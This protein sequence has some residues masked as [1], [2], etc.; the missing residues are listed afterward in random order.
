MK[1]TYLIIFLFLTGLCI[2]SEE[3][4]DVALITINEN[5]LNYDQKRIWDHLKPDIIKELKKSFNLSLISKKSE[6]SLFEKGLNSIKTK[7]TNIFKVNPYPMDYRAKDLA[8]IL[9]FYKYTKYEWIIVLEFNPTELDDNPFLISK[10]ASSDLS[11]EAEESFR[12][13]LKEKNLSDEEIAH[14]I[15]SMKGNIKKEKV[16]LKTQEKATIGG[17]FGVKVNCIDTFLEYTLCKDYIFK[18]FNASSIEYARLLHADIV[19]EIQKIDDTFIKKFFRNVNKSKIYKKD[20]NGK[21][22]FLK[23]AEHGKTEWI[24]TLLE[25]GVYPDQIA[26]N[27]MSALMLASQ[28]GHTEI[29]KLLLGKGAD[30]GLESAE[31]KTALDYARDKGKTQIV[32]VLK[33]VKIAQPKVAHEKITGNWQGAY[34]IDNDVYFMELEIFEESS[35]VKGKGIIWTG[36]NNSEKNKALKAKLTQAKIDSGYRFLAQCDFDV[37]I[38]DHEI[39]IKNR[40]FKVLG[41]KNK[42]LWY[43][44]STHFGSGVVYED[45]TVTSLQGQINSNNRITGSVNNY[46]EHSLFCLENKDEPDKTVYTKIG[47][48][49]TVKITCADFPQFHY[50]IYIPTKFDPSKIPLII[51]FDSPNGNANPLQIK[52]AEELNIISIG[53]I[54]SSNDGTVSYACSFAVVYDLKQRFKNIENRIVF[55]GFSGGASRSDLRVYSYQDYAVGAICISGGWDLSPSVGKYCFF[56]FGKQEISSD[57]F[58]KKFKSEYKDLIEYEIHPGGH[59]WYVPHLLD[60]AIIWMKQKYDKK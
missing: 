9:P 41:S 20:E 7:D 5:R 15:Q 24:R 34:I 12:K 53:L 19:Q 59:E 40:T 45:P 39:I 22:I 50:N 35:R 44:G 46:G 3:K 55:A 58:L 6:I 10:Q 48:G 13:Q 60:Q 4:S 29:V 28:N 18:D 54:E 16:E 42:N 23:A 11:D 57:E 30:A 17:I 38:R 37:Y 52:T 2:Y 25:R 49:N 51:I 47:K 32:N 26:D 14:I 31:N 56:I 33:P 1:R 8:E 43:A 36:I 21:N 27:G